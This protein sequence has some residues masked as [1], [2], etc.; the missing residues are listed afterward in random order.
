MASVTL[1]VPLAV[2]GGA[3]LSQAL[4]RMQLTNFTSALASRTFCA[5]RQD[6]RA[7]RPPSDERGGIMD[8]APDGSGA[9]PGLRSNEGTGKSLLTAL[10]CLDVADLLDGRVH[11]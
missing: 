2:R 8:K 10:F 5:E 4:F 1:W 7:L 9:R 11:V 3:K 6:E